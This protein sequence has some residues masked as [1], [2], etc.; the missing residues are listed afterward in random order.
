LVV[1]PFKL[2][3]IGNRA[4][5]VAGSQAWN[6]LPEDIASMQSLSI[7]RRRRKTDLFR[8]SFPQ[9]L[10]VFFLFN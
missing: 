1:P 6:D 9:H 5:P 2:S 7:F 4:F 10:I 8:Q 3:S